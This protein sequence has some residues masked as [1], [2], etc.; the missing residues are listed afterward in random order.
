MS[1]AQSPKAGIAVMLAHVTNS[2]RKLTFACMSPSPG[3]HCSDP[4]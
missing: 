3:P 2:V 1:L 4:M